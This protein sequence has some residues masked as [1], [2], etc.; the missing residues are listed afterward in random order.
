MLDGS[1]VPSP[2]EQKARYATHQNTPDNAGYVAMF[3]AFLRDGVDPFVRSPARALDF[4]CGPLPP[5]GIPVLAGLLEVRGFE[6]DF[7]DPFFSPETPWR[8][9][10]YDLVTLTEV[11][12]HVTDPLGILESLRGRLTGR[13]VIALTTLFHPEDKREFGEWWYRRDSTHVSFYSPATIRR[14]A[15]VLGLEVLH[16]DGKSLATLGMVR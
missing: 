10:T 6:T 14:L 1:Q 12:E 16:I 4:G 3:E 2:E 8:E 15:Q 11:L 5:G 7:Y 9:R 13:G